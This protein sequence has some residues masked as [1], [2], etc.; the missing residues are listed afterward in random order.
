MKY[1]LKNIAYAILLL[2]VFN[3]TTESVD[4]SQE[5][6]S[7]IQPQEVN[8]DTPDVNT[9][10]DQDPKARIT[11]NGTIDVNLE[12]YNESGTLVGQ[13]YNVT[14]GHT[15]SWN[16]FSVGEV[17][18]VVSNVNANK[19]IVLDMDTCTVYDMVVGANNQLMSD[20]LTNDD[21]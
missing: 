8:L 11:N 10:N 15:S 12:I 20:Q 6:S 21:D 16:E 4:N 18:F 14:P 2:S 9:C 1:L 3:C 7:T 19:A 5:S 17:T 13:A